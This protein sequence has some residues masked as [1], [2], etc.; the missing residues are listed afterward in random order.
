MLLW[1][2][3]WPRSTYSNPPNK[4]CSRKLVMLHGVTCNEAP[5]SP[6]SSLTMN[7]NHSFGGLHNLKKSLH[8]FHRRWCT[9]SK[10]Q[11]VMVDSVLDKLFPIIS[12]GI[13]S[14]Y[15]LHS[16]FLEY[17]NELFRTKQSILQS[18]QKNYPILIF[19]SIIR[20]AE[21]DQLIRNNPIKVSIFQ[22]FVVFV[23]TEIELLET[24]PPEL[25]CILQPLQTL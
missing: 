4:G 11:I 3:D 5:C 23:L 19:T 15:S 1:T 16:K 8:D 13:Q 22:L 24:E 21:S 9:V 25:N 12:R 2:K 18:R 14:Y 10:V 17:W 7:S 6:Q 20:R